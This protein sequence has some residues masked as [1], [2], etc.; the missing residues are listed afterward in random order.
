MILILSMTMHIEI[1]VLGG[2]IVTDKDCRF[3]RETSIVGGLRVHGQHT[4]SPLFR[5]QPPRQRNMMGWV[6]RC[7]LRQQLEKVLV[8]VLGCMSTV[9]LLAEATL[10]PS[11]VD[12]SF[13][14]ILIKAV[15]EQE[16]LVQVAANLVTWVP[17]F[18]AQQ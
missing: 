2:E 13:F 5:S 14:S 10:L 3:G 17:L 8:V 18:C 7:I 15:G 9:I 1:C 11:E 12:L 6:W 4:Q 16:M